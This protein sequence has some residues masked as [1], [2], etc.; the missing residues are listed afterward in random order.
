MR[1][2]FF[3]FAIAIMAI[4][5]TN[6]LSAQLSTPSASPLAKVETVIGMTD[7]HATY[8]RP[9]KKGRDLFSKDGLVPTG[10]IWRTGANQATKLTFGGD[11]T[12]GGKEVKAGDYAILTKPMGSTWEVMMYPYESGS[13]NSYVEK[14]P[15]VTVSIKATE[16]ALSLETFTITTMNH[17]MDGADVIFAWGNTMAALPV[18]TSAKKDVMDQIERVMAGPSMNDYYQAASF[19]ADNGDNKKGLEYIKKANEMAGDDARFWMVRR[20]GLIE[21]SLGMKK[22]AMASFKKSLELAEK[23]G[24]MDYVRMNK[25]SL[26]M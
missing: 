13:W 4:L 17:T 7:F 2:Q 19:L 10:E 16:S 22:E 15:A 25:K 26:G 23:A 9:G 11:V 1:K 24:N 20:Q 21:E 12:V 6:G 18:K 5:F 14:T 8:S 3:T